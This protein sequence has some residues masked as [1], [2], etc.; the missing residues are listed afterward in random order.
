MSTNVI[1]GNSSERFLKRA[2]LRLL[3]WFAPPAGSPPRPADL[4]KVRRILVIKPDER[5]GN[6]VLVT[7]LLVALKGRFSRAHQVCLISRRYW[8]LRRHLPSTD[9]FIAFDKR[10]LARNPWRFVRLIRLLRGMKFDLA[11][12]AAGDHTLSFTHLAISALCGARFRVGHARGDAARF[13]EVAVPVPDTVRHASEMHVDLLRAVTTIRSTPRLLLRP[14]PDSGFVE[15]FR[16]ENG[17]DAAVPLIVVHPGARGRKQWPP[18]E[19]A[20]MMRK[21]REQTDAAIALIWGPADREVAESVLKLAS[22]NVY[23]VGVLSFDDLISLLRHAAAYVSADAGPMHLAVAASTPV[24][25]IFLASDLEKYRP[26][27]RFDQVLDGRE[28]PP[29][30]GQVARAVIDV[31]N[32]ARQHRDLRS[33]DRRVREAS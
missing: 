21:L 19:F 29:D 1:S 17:L 11:F 18:E 7:A 16:R 20:A 10:R 26:Q 33:G 24:V 25:A 2:G 3:G 15:R 5:L 22:D 28:R 4:E 14:Q 6:A 23:P 32:Q 31:M 27:G 9:E 30:P 8:D 13:Y 12:D